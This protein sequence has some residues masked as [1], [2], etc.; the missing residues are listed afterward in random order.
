V[1]N[2]DRSS[3]F[4]QT[5]EVHG[6]GTF[7]IP[8]K[9][10]SIQGTVT[11]SSTGQPIPNATVQIQ[12]QGGGFLGSQMVNTDPSGSFLAENVA[13]GTYHVVVQKDGYGQSSRDITV[14]DSAV[15]PLQFKLSPSDGITITVVDARDQTPLRANATRVIDNATGQPVS[16]GGGFG[17]GGG[18]PEPIKLSLAPG[19]YSVTIAAQGYASKIV[20]VSS[21]SQLTVGLTAGGTVTFRSKASTQLRARLLDASGAVYRNFTLDASPLTTTLN[22][23]AAGNYTLQLLDS[24]GAVVN[25][26]P[27]TVVDGQQNVFDV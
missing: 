18:A 4:S 24:S 1:I 26:I 14:T 8:I 16:V 5:Y 2:L 12:N 21:P 17:F 25:T 27:I 11:D 15:D 7:D 19:S 13:A 10:I 20:T 9:T 23:V 3:A 6:S 22:T